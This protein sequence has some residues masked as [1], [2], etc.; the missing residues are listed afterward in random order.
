VL[1]PLFKRRSPLSL[2]TRFIARER[3]PKR[4][5][6]VI[7]PMHLSMSLSE[8]DDTTLLPRVMGLPGRE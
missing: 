4:I 8:H 7:L 1:Q 6:P 3:L 2:P 5:N